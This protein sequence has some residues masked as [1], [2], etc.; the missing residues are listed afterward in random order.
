MSDSS[1][2]PKGLAACTA[3]ALVG[4]TV[5]LVTLIGWEPNDLYLNTEGDVQHGPNY[6]FY[7]L[8][9]SPLEPLSPPQ[10]LADS[11]PVN[12]EDT[13][14]APPTVVAS[15]ISSSPQTNAW[16]VQVGAFQDAREADARRAELLLLGL[17]AHVETGA[18][19]EGTPWHRVLIGPI[20]SGNELESTQLILSEAKI[21]QMTKTMQ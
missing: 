20:E 1:T 7:D 10:E 11:P 12:A 13:S 8:T 21:E 18:D 4:L 16:V 5:L 6:A 3:I 19:T 2:F 14:I 17:N 9:G 15:T